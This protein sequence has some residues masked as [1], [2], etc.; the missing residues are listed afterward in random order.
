MLP[1]ALV[2]PPSCAPGHASCPG[3]GCG[4]QCCRDSVSRYLSQTVILCQGAEVLAQERRSNFGLCLSEFLSQ[5]I[6]SNY[7]HWGKRK[8]ISLHLLYR[9]LP[10]KCTQK[11]LLR[12][13]IHKLFLQ[14]GT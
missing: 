7:M 14:H 2:L 12:L 10:T 3:A 8:A 11:K 13:M 9:S 6:V 1:H 4:G 5:S